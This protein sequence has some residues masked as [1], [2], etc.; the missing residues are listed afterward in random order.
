MKSS[1]TKWGHLVVW[2]MFFYG[3]VYS[4]GLQGQV[5]QKTQGKIFSAFC[6]HNNSPDRN[7]KNKPTS[8]PLPHADFKIVYHFFSQR[9]W[10]RAESRVTENLKKYGGSVQLSKLSAGSSSKWTRCLLNWRHLAWHH[11]GFITR[12]HWTL[13]VINIFEKLLPCETCVFCQTRTL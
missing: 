9:H 3:R 4:T 5:W 8:T 11:S 7:N 13:P 12:H 1:G 10:T 2:K 6:Y